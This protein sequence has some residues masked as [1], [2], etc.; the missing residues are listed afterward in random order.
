MRFFGCE[1]RKE[2]YLK[3]IDCFLAN[4]YH[5]IHRDNIEAII[6]EKE[7]RIQIVLDTLA[8]ETKLQMEIGCI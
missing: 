1:Y 5:C 4:R 7:R 3:D 2:C 6:A 8:E